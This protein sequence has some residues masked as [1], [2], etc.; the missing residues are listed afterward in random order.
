MLL[1]E[2]REGMEEAGEVGGWLHDEG[3]LEV[4]RIVIAVESGS[5]R[6]V[7]FIGATDDRKGIGWRRP[8]RRYAQMMS[9]KAQFRAGRTM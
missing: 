7:K 2:G 4:P 3:R 1:E 5:M 9:G 6:N 8:K